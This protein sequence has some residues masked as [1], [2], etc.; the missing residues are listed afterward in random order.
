MMFADVMNET[1]NEHKAPLRVLLA[2]ASTLVREGL[3]Q[4][5]AE[6]DGVSVVG[7][8]SSCADLQSLLRSTPAD[9]ILLDLG[10][11]CADIFAALISHKVVRPQV[12]VIALSHL[13]SPALDQ[14]CLQAGA[15]YVVSKTAGLEQLIKVVRHFARRP[16]P[17]V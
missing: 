6:L 15:D 16:P 8:A 2:E 13:C 17:A 3:R 7:E 11:P 14:R 1:L 4:M 12:R 10:L 5:L 9:L